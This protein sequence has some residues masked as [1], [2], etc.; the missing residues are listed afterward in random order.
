MGSNP[1]TFTSCGSECPVE[2]VSWDDIQGFIQKLNAKTGQKYRLPSESEWEY[3]ARGGTTTEYP[4]GNNASHDYANYGTDDCC[5]GKAEGRDQWVN[6]APVG[7][8]PANGFGLHDMHGN[9][10]EWTQDCYH[11]SYK[12]APQDG[13]AWESDSCAKRV[14]RGGGWLNRPASLR[15][16]IRV[17]SSASDR[18]S[19]LGFRL[20]QGR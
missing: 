5:E 7:K 10:W 15:S 6:T 13:S 3:A 18:S 12:G 9:V 14:L 2:E 17:R 20:V 19:N 1:S 8:F 11:D 4:W 16:A